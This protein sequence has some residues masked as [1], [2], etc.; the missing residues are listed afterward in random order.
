MRRLY[1]V[2][3]AAVGLYLNSVLFARVNIS[4]IRPD[5]I[6][7]LTAS[8]G[9]LL[10]MKKGALFGLITG[11]VADVL[12]SPMVGLSAMGY[13]F[14]GL[15]GGAFYQKYYADNIIIPALV[16][17]VGAIFKECVMAAAC[18][19]GGAAF[20]FFAVL[21]T[22]ILPCALLSAVMCMPVHAL[23]R[24]ALAGQLKAERTYEHDSRAQ[25]G[26]K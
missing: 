7:A 5:A 14:T 2:M 12:F 25:G 20:G 6:I 23:M 8:L 24:R 22:Y 9:V 17:A 11:L 13:M 21:G 15:V 10:G 1:I 18:A 26:V 19:I 3:A 16:A 4:G